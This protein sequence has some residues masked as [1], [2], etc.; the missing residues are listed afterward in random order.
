V[1]A[2]GFV[3][4]I[5]VLVGVGWLQPVQVERWRRGQDGGPTRSTLRLAN[6]WAD[7]AA[8]VVDDLGYPL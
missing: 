8:A 5:E 2:R 1:A 7:G 6:L 3:T 4:V